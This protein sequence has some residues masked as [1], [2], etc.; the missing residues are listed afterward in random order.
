MFRPLRMLLQPLVV[1]LMVSSST[2]VAAPA[3]CK[4]LTD[5]D[6]T[7]FSALAVLTGPN[8]ILGG[9]IAVGSN[10]ALS[11][12]PRVFAAIDKALPALSMCVAETNPL[13][14]VA[15]LMASPAAGKC[16][17]ELS[18]LDK[19][20]GSSGVTAATGSN[21]NSG[22]NGDDDTD[23]SVFHDDV[24][25]A[26]AKL[27]PCLTDV[28]MPALERA[29]ADNTHGCCD[30]LTTE[31]TGAF[32]GETLRE[33]VSSLMGVVGNAL[34]TQRERG[35][36]VETCGD[37]LVN[38]W[39]PPDV[40]QD[41][42]KAA[43]AVLDAFQIPNDQVCRAVASK[44]FKTTTD[45][46]QQY[47]AKGITPYGTCYAPMDALLTYTRDLPL[48]KLGGK[49]TVAVMNDV[50]GEARCLPGKQFIAWAADENGALLKTMRLADVVVSTIATMFSGPAPTPEPTATA[51]NSNSGDSEDSSTDC[52]GSGDDDAEDGSGSNDQQEPGLFEPN[53]GD[54]GG[55]DERHPPVKKTLSRRRL[56]DASNFAA[57]T[58][59][60][61]GQIEYFASSMCLHLP[62]GVTCDF[63]G[64]TLDEP[65]AL[66]AKNS[67][68]SQ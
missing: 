37:A 20:T 55:D 63:P 8:S 62:N 22:E 16:W 38:N 3:S 48:W 64:E 26:A 61:V 5:G 27:A 14:L 9:S 35:G 67:S 1:A 50:F 32:G 58:K 25:P 51:S 34:C 66:N 33:T 65:F 54:D 4:R 60:M 45:K 6:S 56:Q 30:Q 10:P 68:S 7:F 15:S 43:R 52:S 17:Q 53:G 41:D 39:L 46:P 36:E 49:E 12:D 18:L 59:M 21:S 28:L 19:M 42:E 11:L 47:G 40:T 13:N 2:A 44:P 23:S 24:C 29:M 31:I 57:V